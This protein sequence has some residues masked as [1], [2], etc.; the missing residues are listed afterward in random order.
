MR[1]W[2]VGANS[3]VA[4]TSLTSLPDGRS[5]DAQ[6]PATWPTPTGW[7]MLNLDYRYLER[8]RACLKFSRWFSQQ[9]RLQPSPSAGQATHRRAGACP[10]SLAAVRTLLTSA[11]SAG[12]LICRPIDTLWRYIRAVFKSSA[13]TPLMAS[14]FVSSLCADNPLMLEPRDQRRPVKVYR[15]LT[16]IRQRT[17]TCW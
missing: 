17:P 3:A 5:A 4:S 10:R 1:A 14:G 13:L 11:P 9:R 12:I 2:Y 6:V 7:A 15:I 16:G 8:L